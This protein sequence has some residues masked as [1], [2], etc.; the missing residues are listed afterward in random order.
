[1]SKQNA[2]KN[3]LVQRWVPVKDQSG[4]VHMEARWVAVTETAATKQPA[5][6]SAA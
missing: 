1:M 3:G 4:R 6:H 5:A 2:N